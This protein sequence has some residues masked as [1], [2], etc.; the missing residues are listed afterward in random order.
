MNTRQAPQYITRFLL[1]L[2]LSVLAVWLIS[3]VGLLL[4]QDENTARAP[5]QIILTIP[6]GTAVKVANGEPAPNIPDEMTFV[7]GDVLVVR[8]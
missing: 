4:Q 5:A 1:I 8:K 7:L 2:F 3:E 6:E